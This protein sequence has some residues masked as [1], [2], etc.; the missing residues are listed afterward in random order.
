MKLKTASRIFFFT[1]F[2][3]AVFNITQAFHPGNLVMAVLAIFAIASL[4]LSFYV[5]FAYWRCPQCS[6]YLG[7]RFNHRCKKC[8]QKIEKDDVLARRSITFRKI[9]LPDKNHDS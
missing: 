1:A 4:L 5:M 8:G 7:W 2:M 6:S 3:T 9:S